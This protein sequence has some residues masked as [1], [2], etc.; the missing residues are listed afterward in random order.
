MSDAAA[1]AYVSELLRDDVRR[2]H[3]LVAANP[4]AATRCFHWTVRLV[5][6]TL[7]N[8]ADKPGSAEDG[9]PA[10]CESGVFGHVRAF[11]GVVEP[12]MRKAAKV[13][14]DPTRVQRYPITKGRRRAKVK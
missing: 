14:D 2:L 8:C 10:H 13:R 11:F 1:A 5:I 3:S 6:R 9:I 4:L 12:Q 7:F